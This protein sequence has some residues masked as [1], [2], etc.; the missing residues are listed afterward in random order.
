[1]FRGPVRRG[2]RL[3]ALAIGLAFVGSTALAD[4]PHRM[5][6]VKADKVVVHKAA[7]RLLLLRNGEVVKSYRIALGQNPAGPKQRQGD[8]RTPEGRYSLDWR[9]PESRFYRSI[10]VSYPSARDISRARQRGL[11]PGG[12]IMIHG[13]PEGLEVIGAT[14]AK[15]DWTDGC[16]AVTNAEMDEIWS[17]VEDGT[18]IQIL[19]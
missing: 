7:R 14:H 9:N 17:R 2:V 4:L 16:I 15:W 5:P 8:G 19:P 11:P 10:H 18:P 6:V 3:W 1:M 13:L 12:N